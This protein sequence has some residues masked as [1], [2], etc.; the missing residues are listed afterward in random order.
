[1]LTPLTKTSFGPFA[2]GA[3]D[4]ASPLLDNSQSLV[5]ASNIYVKGLNVMVRRGGSTVVMS[6]QDDQ[7]TPALV[8][9][10]RLVQPFKDR[11]IVAAHSTVTSKTYLYLVDSA[12]TGWYDTSDTFTAATTASPLLV[13]YSSQPV[14][15]D[16]L[17][18]EGLGMAYFAHTGASSA[19]SLNWPTYQLNFGWTWNGG[20][21]ATNTLWNLN[22]LVSDLDGSGAKTIYFLGVTQFQ[23]HLWGW[24][25]GHGSV[26]STGF[27]PSM[28]RWSN[29]IFAINGTNQNDLFNSTDDLT[30]GDRVDSAREQ[31]ITCL[32]AGEALFCFSSSQ[33]ARITGYG[34]DSWQKVSIDRSYGVVGPKAACVA[35]DYVYYWSNRG[36]MRMFGGLVSDYQYIRPEPLWDRIADASLAALSGGNPAG[37]IACFARD[38]DQVQF[39]YQSRETEGTVRFAAYDVRR[40]QWLGPASAIGTS[41]ACAGAIEPIYSVTSPPAGPSGNPTLTAA[42]DIS[43]SGFTINWLAGDTTA[44]TLVEYTPAGQPFTSE[45]TTGPGVTSFPVTGVGPGQAF[46]VR[47][48]LLKNGQLSATSTQLNYVTTAELT[49]AQPSDLAVSPAAFPRTPDADNAYITWKVNEPD[50]YTGVLMLGPGDTEYSQIALVDPN[51]SSYTLKG[52]PSTDPASNVYEFRV[53]AAKVNDQPS[54]PTS[55]VAVTLHTYQSFG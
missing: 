36:P 45:T 28:M 9:S 43:T 44:D 8:T 12:F 16:I 49:A 50:S 34:T 55:P 35:G 18:A 6:F 54:L 17:M 11:V 27:N 5:E 10:I 19:T 53:Y 41:I 3:I 30:L 22:P 26:A 14:A 2:K 25:F 46:D 24:G 48:T 21:P 15:P 13:L 52:L 1:M 4:A 23:Q 37:I 47:V 39:Y 33:C 31:V 20:S 32:A 42:T 7:G 51:K 29:P 40:D 38:L